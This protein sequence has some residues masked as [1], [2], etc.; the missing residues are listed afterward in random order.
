MPLLPDRDL[1]SEVLG[2]PLLQDR[3]LQSEVLGRCH[4]NALSQAGTQNAE[5]AFWNVA[6]ERGAGNAPERKILGAF[7]KRNEPRNVGTYVLERRSFRNVEPQSPK[8]EFP[9]RV[10]K[11]KSLSRK[12]CNS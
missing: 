10:V 5:R 9:D 8:N 11:F 12:P 6:S 2:R 7:D 4:S 1:E 3:E